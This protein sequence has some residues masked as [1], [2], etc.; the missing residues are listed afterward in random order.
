[1]SYASLV[2]FF[3]THL[4]VCIHTIL[5]A[6]SIYPASTFIRARAYNYPVM[7]SRHPGVCEW[8][9]DAVAAVEAELLKGTVARVAMVIFEAWRDGPSDNNNENAGEVT[10][11]F[12]SSGSAITGSKMGSGGERT[13]PLERYVWDVSR[14]PEIPKNER[15]TLLARE[16]PK[17][18]QDKAQEDKNAAAPAEEVTPEERRAKFQ[19][20]LKQLHSDMHEQFRGLLARLSTISSRLAPLPDVD[21]CTFTLC[22]ELKEECDPPI[23]HPQAWIPSES[24]LQRR[25]LH[26][27]EDEDMSDMRE[28]EGGRPIERGS[29]LGGVRTR[30]VRSVNSGEMLFEMWIEENKAKFDE[31]TEKG[32]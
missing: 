19:A 16:S 15:N 13:R 11:E 24:E 5:A 25:V 26:P 6:R 27:K 21:R 7:Q 18:P 8:I 12:D 28:K 17:T 14:W 29:E 20:T 2:S 32:S 31:Q 3:T 22:V 9:N 4:T 23:G 30:P 10:S 1:M